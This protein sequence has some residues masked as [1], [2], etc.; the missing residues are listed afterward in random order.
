METNPKKTPVSSPK[1]RSVKSG[2]T[3]KTVVPVEEKPVDV[4]ERLKNVLA[5]VQENKEKPVPKKAAPVKKKE[6]AKKKTTKASSKTT[7]KKP[8]SAKKK[9]E[10]KKR[11]TAS[12]EE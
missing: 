8:A 7:A 5:E 6:P 9:S 3:K 12:L 10:A 2:E 11:P 1:K 4:V